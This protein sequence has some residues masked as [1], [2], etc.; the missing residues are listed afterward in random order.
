MTRSYYELWDVD[1]PGRWYLLGLYDGNGRKL[2]SRFFTYG[3]A[4]DLGPPMRIPSFREGII[5]EAPPPLQVPVDRPGQELDFTFDPFD[6][7]VVTP[8]VGELLGAIVGKEIQR[9]P[10]LAGR[11][12]D[13]EIINVV[14]RVA[15]IDTAH[16]VI[17]W[18]TKDDGRPDLVGQPRMISKLVLD[19][20][21]A[22][23]H[24]FFRLQDWDVALIASD[25]VKKAF[26]EAHVSGVAFKEV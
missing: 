2:D 20:D 22:E 4:V 15:C 18:W 3:N 11:G 6:M 12:E 7:P 16:S 1:L 25:L 14:S 5:V 26:E 8:K 17:M 10:V 23:G 9:I 24:H 19:R 13:Y 21:R